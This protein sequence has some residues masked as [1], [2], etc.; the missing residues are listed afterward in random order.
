M[1]YD[2]NNSFRQTEQ[3]S[4]MSSGPDWNWIGYINSFDDEN[5]NYSFAIF[6]KPVS[7]V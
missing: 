1:A 6:G 3:E 5:N 4:T 7:L 2:D